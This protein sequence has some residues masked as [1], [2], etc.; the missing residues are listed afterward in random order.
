MHRNFAAAIGEVY[1]VHTARIVITHER[2]RRRIEVSGAIE[3]TECEPV[4]TGEPVSSG[5]PGHGHPGEELVAETL[6]V[7]SDPLRF[8]FSGRC[9]FAT[10]FDYRSDI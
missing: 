1:G 7:D 5:V 8:A 6:E 9:G 4:L 3:M 10:E 2:R